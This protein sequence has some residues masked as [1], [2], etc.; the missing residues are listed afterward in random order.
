MKN[1]VIQ[2]VF[3]SIFVAISF[4]GILNAAGLLGGSPNL[5]FLLYYTNLSNIFCFVI[6]LIILIANCKL[7]LKGEAEGKNESYLKLN[8]YA[9]IAIFVTF[10]VYNLLLTDN[11]FG[12]GWNEIGNLTMHIVCPIL[13]IVN[14]FLFDKKVTLKWFDPLLCIVLPLIYVV[15]IMIRGAL[16]GKGYTGMVYPYFFLDVNELGYNGVFVWV[17][18]LLAVF[19]V[20]GYLFFIYNHC[21]IE[22]KKL[23]FKKC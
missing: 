7:V 19:I 4:M 12:K 13:F 23:K 11:M 16:V 22:D 1:R 21:T 20:L 14:W 17:I 3:Q 15:F 18:I 10:A 9:T 2:I 6:M 5:T 8:F